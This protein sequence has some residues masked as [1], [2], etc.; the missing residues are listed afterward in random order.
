M[1]HVIALPAVLTVEAVT[2]AR[3]P[4]LRSLQG[5]AA[6]TPVVLDAA[7]VRQFDSAGL[8]LLLAA[9]RQ[10]QAL[11]QSLVVQGWPQSLRALAQVYGVLELLDPHSASAA[12]TSG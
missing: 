1:S 4:L 11:Q 10:A 12:V 7:A 2:A 3:A 8:A 5:L 6:G 9:R